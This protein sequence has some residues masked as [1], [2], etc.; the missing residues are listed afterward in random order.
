MGL[1]LLTSGHFLW[2]A[3][4]GMEIGLHAALLAGALGMAAH[5]GGAATAA[6]GVRRLAVLS[7]LLFLLG[8]ARPEGILLGGVIALG[9]IYAGSGPNSARARGALLLAPLA[10]ALLT[11]AANLLA[12]GVLTPNSVAAKAVWNEPRPDVRDAAVHRLPEIAARIARALFSDFGSRSWGSGTGY[13][14][15]GLLGI[16]A[17]AAVAFA[18]RRRGGA[19]ERILLAVLLGAVLTGLVPVGFNAHHHRYQ[20]PYLPVVTVLVVSGWWRL[21]A[22]WPR[23]RWVPV[24]L[25]AAL[26]L[27]SL[28]RFERHLA[29]NAGN[30]HDQQVATGRWIHDHLPPDARVA[31]NDAGA[32]AYYGERTVI[33][34]VGLVTNGSALPNRGGPGTLY[35]WLESLPPERRPTHFAIFP[36]WYPYLRKTSLVGEK[37]AQFTL[38]TNTISGSD[39]KAVYVANWRRAEGADALWTRRPLV[40]LWGFQV[41]DALDVGDLADQARHAYLAFSTWRSVLREFAVE[42]QPGRLLVDGGL[43]PSR[44]ERFVLRARPGTPGALVWRTEAYR[45]FTFNVKLNGQD[46]GRWEIPALPVTWSEALFQIPGEAV[47]GDS[48]TVEITLAGAAEGYPS[49]QY[50]LLQ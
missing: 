37:L 22:G 25:I 41:V 48:V 16:G 45:D 26:Q 50:W 1:L 42:G 35:E 47:T 34:L 33:D 17:L 49:Y 14:L 9:V 21:L 3:M 20:I 12:L 43:E 23:W 32:I 44:G 29:D 2:G 46:A 19:G 36:A 10:A 7:A 40:E 15:E 8:L 30:I 18:F 6:S 24:A 4:S 27:P 11:A 28:P 31:I 5:H 13:V 38:G 39:V